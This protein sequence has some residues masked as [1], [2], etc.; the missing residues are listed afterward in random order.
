MSDDFV[1]G[2]RGDLVG[3]M[4]RYERSRPPARVARGAART[5]ASRRSPRSPPPRRWSSRSSSA[6]RHL[7]QPEHVSGKLKPVV[8]VG[9]V[10]VD[11]R[12]NGDAI[13]IADLNG[14]LTHVDAASGPCRDERRRH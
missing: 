8:K 12:A 4:E 9:G 13:W 5:Q 7:P 1:T 14:R 6:I 2:L 3:A 10:P 11:V